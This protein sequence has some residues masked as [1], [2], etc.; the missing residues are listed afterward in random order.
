LFKNPDRADR[1]KVT[2]SVPR[3]AGKPCPTTIVEETDRQTG[4]THIFEKY[5]FYLFI[6]PVWCLDFNV[7]YKNNDQG[8]FL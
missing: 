6:N 2:L 8:E 7:L 4:K 1:L 5:L 3:L